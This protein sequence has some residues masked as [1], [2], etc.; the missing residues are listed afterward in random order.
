VTQLEDL[1]WNTFFDNQID[2]SDRERWLFGRVIEEQRDAWCVLTEHAELRADLAGRARH[3]ANARADLPAVGDWVGLVPRYDERR[4]TIHRVLN[5]RTQF[6]RRAAGQR[7]EQIVAANVDVGF[8]VSS[9]N[10]ELNLRRLERYLTLVWDSGATPV[11]LLTKSDLCDDVEATLAEV[12]SIA[13]GV[14]VH[15]MSALSGQGLDAARAYLQPG[16]TAA[17][18]GSSGVGKSTLI[19]ALAGRDLLRTADISVDRQRGRHTTTARHLIRLP[20]N[21]MVIDTPGMREL[22]AWDA[23]EGVSRTFEDIEQLSQACRFTNCAHQTEPGC[24]IR[25]ALQTG[26]LDESRWSSY[27][28]LLREQ[29]YQDRRDD[30]AALAEQRRQWKAIHKQAKRAQRQKGAF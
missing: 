5:R 10:A 25:A 4:A 28:K 8:V 24:A 19:N 18:I 11:V 13:A 17:A 21:S 9:M 15:A 29:A 27:Q 3:N 6:V 30:P 23:Q 2:P 20:N 16:L 14:A 1:G 22:E 7:G 12:E 26:A